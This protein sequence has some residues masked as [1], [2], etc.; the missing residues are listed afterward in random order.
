M[1]LAATNFPWELDDALRR[2]LEKRIYIPLPDYIARLQLL[3]LSLKDVQ[4][5]ANVNLENIARRLEGYS[6]ADIT[7]FCR[8]VGAYCVLVHT[9]YTGTQQ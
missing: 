5:G 3:Q 8:C 7:N 2:R 4:L 6:G 9:G 1:V